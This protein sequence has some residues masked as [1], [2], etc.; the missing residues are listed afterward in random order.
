MTLTDHASSVVKTLLPG[1][2]IFSVAR[3]SIRWAVAM[4]TRDFGH[5]Y[6][7]VCCQ[8]SLGEKI[9]LFGEICN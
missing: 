3:E 4:V 2:D 1:D 6:W 7:G 5:S 9:D 8:S